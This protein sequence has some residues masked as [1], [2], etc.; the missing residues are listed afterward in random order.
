[1]TGN[2]SFAFKQMTVDGNQIF[3][4]DNAASDA[5]GR[6]FDRDDMRAGFVPPIC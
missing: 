3:A 6:R 5:V 4:K 2:F 1:M